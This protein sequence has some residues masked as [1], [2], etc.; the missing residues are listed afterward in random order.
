MFGEIF[1]V[2]KTIE[3][4]C[5]GT[6]LTDNHEGWIQAKY[7]G[8]YKENNY[9]IKS[10]SSNIYLYPDAKSIVLKYLSLGSTVYAHKIENDWATISL[11]SKNSSKT[12]FIPVNHLTKVTEYKCDWINTS[13]EMLNT[14]YV[15]GGR[16]SNG[17]DCSALLQLSFQSTGINLPRNTKEQV[18][19]MKTSQRFKEID[20][21]LLRKSNI[22]KGFIIFW[23]GHVGI[24]S[25]KNI[26]LHANA[27]HM[28][29]CEENI[30]SV[31][32]RFKSHNIF[33]SFVFQLIDI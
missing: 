32:N 12:G 2:Y 20:L 26:L 15:W 25:K 22:Q 21:D 4:W 23:P 14:P 3:D 10:K 13:Y 7:L 17:I 8:S 30:F 9:R 16:T 18:L 11:N 19:F 1:S 31:F 27:Y 29:V 6:L 5:F 33:P 24:M 28:N